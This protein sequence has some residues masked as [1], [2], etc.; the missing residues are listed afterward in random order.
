M[1]TGT[2]DVAAVQPQF[3]D[4]SLILIQA[5]KIYFSF[6]LVESEHLT[7]GTSSKK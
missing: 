2:I 4:V 1:N 7:L 5:I 6:S 3:G